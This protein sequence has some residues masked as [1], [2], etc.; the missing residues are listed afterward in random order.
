MSPLSWTRRK[1]VSKGVDSTHEEALAIGDTLGVRDYV[2]PRTAVTLGE[3][4]GS[5][6]F[7]T[8]F[9][10]T[11]SKEVHGEEV[12][13]VAKR[14]Y[15]KRLSASDVPLLKS[16][17]QNWSSISHPNCVSFMGC[18]LHESEYLL[19]CEYMPGGTLETRLAQYLQD[20]R[21][22]PTQDELVAWMAP[23]ADGMK[24]LHSKGIIHRDLKSANV[25]IDNDG[26]LALSD[27]GLSRKF[28]LGKSEFTA[29]TGSYRWMAPEVTRHEPYDEKCDVYSYGCLCYEMTTYRI[30][31]HEMTTLEA[32]F[33]VARDAMRSKIPASCPPVIAKLIA[34]CWQQESERR[35]SFEL[36]CQRLEQLKMR[37]STEE[38]SIQRTD[39][40]R[41]LAEEED[42][43]ASSST[44]SL[45]RPKSISS[46]LVDMTVH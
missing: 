23:L 32:A 21:P 41:R 22:P 46:A 35:P 36:I 12:E 34:D 31:L 11:I 38:P 33:A 6:G 17:A 1:S 26:R 42:Q 20:G 37:A 25:L 44:A 45:K 13:A 39:S 28:D 15:P 43:A 4:L 19:L 8:V 24:Y 40:K 9:A 3:K 10:C 5:G 18:C 2:I 29:E 7:G 30:P 16:E 27:F 14:I